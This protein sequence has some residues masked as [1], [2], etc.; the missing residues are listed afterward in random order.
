MFG[1][2]LSK[3]GQ[4]MHDVFVASGLEFVSQLGLVGVAMHWVTDKQEVK[5]LSKFALDK[6]LNFMSNL[7]LSHSNN[8]QNLALL[9]LWI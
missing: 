4:F 3:M 8:D 2:V 6:L 9:I 5:F 1:H 7:V